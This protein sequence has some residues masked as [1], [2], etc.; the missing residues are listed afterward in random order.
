MPHSCGQ[1]R[2]GIS[3]KATGPVGFGTGSPCL[4]VEWDS[5]VDG[6]KGF[7]LEG[8][9]SAGRATDEE[10][11]KP[12]MAVATSSYISRSRI[13]VT[14]APRR[15]QSWQTRTLQRAEIQASSSAGFIAKH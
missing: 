5:K 9:Q 15:L 11:G 7:I 14:F 1:I 3:E 4:L 12:I 6:A 10:D 13:S 8:R 2:Q